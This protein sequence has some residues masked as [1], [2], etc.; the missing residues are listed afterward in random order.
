MSPLSAAEVSKHDYVKHLKWVTPFVGLKR[1]VKLLA[2][3]WAFGGD[4]PC[5]ANVKLVH[6]IRHG[7][8]EHNLESERTGKHCTCNPPVPGEDCPYQQ[9]HLLDPALTDLGREQAISN[10]V[11]TKDFKP[12]VVIVSPL[13]RATETGLLAFEHLRKKPGIFIAH[14][15]VR[16]ISGLHIC[17]KYQETEKSKI[18][19][20]EVDY[21]LVDPTDEYWTYGV[22]EDHRLLIDRGYDFMIWLRDREDTE[23]GVASH[24]AFLLAMFNAILDCQG[25][26]TLTSWFETGEMRSVLVE[27]I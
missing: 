16:E 1:N 8:G 19:F 26:K 4:L 24:S 25:D 3:P 13:I 27:Y 15:S 11:K 5:K 6:F 18:R 21:R 9:P 22:R 2:S 10:Q 17:D 14:S 23:I 12:S 7:Q 20:P